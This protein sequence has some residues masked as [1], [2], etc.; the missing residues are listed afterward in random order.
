[1]APEQALGEPVSAATDAWGIG[2]VLYEAATGHRPFGDGGDDVVVQLRRGRLQLERAA[3]PAARTPRAEGPGTA[4]AAGGGGGGDRRLP[5]TATRPGVPRST[6]WTT[7]WTACSVGA[8]GDRSMVA[9][10]R[11]DRSMATMLASWAPPEIGG[12][13]AAKRISRRR[14]KPS[15]S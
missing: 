10:L 1:M 4:A 7:R 9:L 11:S 2:L 15:C 12:R 14:V 13:S 5:A 8:A 3:V 6:R